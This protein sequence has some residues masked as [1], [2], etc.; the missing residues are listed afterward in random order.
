MNAVLL[1]LAILFIL[2]LCRIHIALAMIIASAV[3]GLTGSLGLTETINVFTEGLK[4]NAAIALSYALLG[5]FAA[6]LTETGLPERLVQRV[7]KLVT[8]K[9]L[10]GRASKVTPVVVVLA[11]AFIACLSQNAVPVHIAFIPVLIPPLLS[12]FNQLHIDRRAI[13]NALT[14]GL[15][16]PYMVLPVGFG[17]IFHETVAA[18][19]SKNGMAIDVSMLPKAMLLPAVGM[20]LGLLTAV[21][22]SYRK[23]KTYKPVQ[24]TTSTTNFE[25]DVDTQTA[26]TGASPAIKTIAGLASI[27]AMLVVQLSTDSMIYGAGSGLIVLLLFRIMSRNRSNQVFTDGMRTMA[28]I[29]FVMMSAAGLGA[30]LRATGDIETLVQSCVE[31]VGSSRPMAAILILIIGLLVTMGIGSSFSTIPLIVTV[32][33]PLCIELGFSPLATTALI[34]TAAALGDA[35]S[36]ASDSTL[37]PTSGL[38]ADGQHDHIWGTCVPTFLHYNIPLLIF[39]FIA[40]MVL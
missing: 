33:V 14:F 20:V 4:D 31:L 37:G 34:G 29:G 8:N 3:G 16:T 5:A 32:F 9:Q 10:S 6:G 25:E 11:V 30:V 40:A 12:L 27:A 15:I 21:F 7:V 17:A 36:P 23:P 24:I 26:G 19:M 39:G 1:S 35:G 18:N 38:N 22:F 28:Y 13:A 2:S